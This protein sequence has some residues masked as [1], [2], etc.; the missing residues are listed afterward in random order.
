VSDK[1]EPIY[2]LGDW[3]IEPHLNRISRGGENARLEAKTMD[4]LVYLVGRAGEVISA[5]ELLSAVWPDRVVEESTVHRRINQIRRAL[6]DDRTPRRYVETIVKRGYRVVADVSVV[7]EEVPAIHPDDLSAPYR[8]R[9]ADHSSVEQ[10]V[11][12]APSPEVSGDSARGEAVRPSRRGLWW[13][14]L[15]AVAVLGVLSVALWSW[16]S[17]EDP[18]DPLEARSAVIVVNRFSSAG[19]DPELEQFAERAAEQIWRSFTS[20]PYVN[21]TSN[22]STVSAAADAS[23][24]GEYHV[25]GKARRQGQTRMLLVAF[26]S[27]DGRVLWQ[28]DFDAA[29]DS[30]EEGVPAAYAAD[31]MAYVAY[32]H[33]TITRRRMPNELEELFL[34]A[35]LSNLAGNRGA[36]YDLMRRVLDVDPD[37]A[38]AHG[39]MIM[40]C[41]PHSELEP[42]VLMRE[43]RRWGR[44][45]IE[46]DPDSLLPYW[47]LALLE[48]NISGDLELAAEYVE[49][50]RELGAHVGW[51]HAAWGD[52]HMQEGRLEEAIRSFRSALDVGVM[53]S[54]D[55]SNW[56]LGRALLYVEEYEAAADA[57]SQA[58]R[59]FWTRNQ[60][61][62]AHPRVIAFA[63][64]GDLAEAERILDEYKPPQSPELLWALGRQDAARVRLAEL[65]S[66]HGEGAPRVTAAALFGG[67]AVM[68]DWEVAV[69]W[70]QQLLMDVRD[71]PAGQRSVDAWNFWFWIPRLYAAD[72]E[73][74]RQRPEFPEIERQIQ[75]IRQAQIDRFA[76]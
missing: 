26:E 15:G 75:E 65:E 19:D 64:L 49:K 63:K 18:I 37:N 6:G 59:R 33:Q 52:I 11:V 36:A 29:D 8:E 76:S 9:E 70:L 2:R 38:T 21:V 73:P 25:R 69:K 20:D 58:Q 13:Y 56:H 68:G 66:S 23:A 74:L 31:H 24:R 57:L 54:V 28:E 27:A 45:A 61:A 10:P 14:S 51:I 44:R 43:R 42:E 17:R 7:D 16:I 34:K 50:A 22:P 53:G 3:L 35:L 62:I 71:D 12:G 40:L 4:V 1:T 72:L 47:Y 67:Y 39:W 48:K 32:L 46:L 41:C 5:D 55:G 30:A 60:E